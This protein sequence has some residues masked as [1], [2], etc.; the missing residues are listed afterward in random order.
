M[1]LWHIEIQHFIILVMTMNISVIQSTI[2]AIEK[3][4]I[5]INTDYTIKAVNQ[6]YR[7]IYDIDVKLGTSRC[8]EVSHK[9]SQ[10]CDKNGESCP[11]QTCIN[12]GKSSSVVHIHHTENGKQFCDILMKPITDE[13]GITIG[14]L[15]ILEDIN[16]ASVEIHKDKMIG[17]SKPFLHL[18]KQVNRA[19]NSEIAVLLQ[20][21]TGVGKELVAN[22]LHSESKRAKQPFVVIECTG[23][24]EN[25]FES[26]LFGHEKG[27]FTGATQSK[28]GLIDLAHGGTVFFDEI[29]DIPLNMQVKLLRLLETKTY[30]AVGSLKQKT[31]NF[32]FLAATHKDLLKLVEK[33]EFREDL[34]YRIAGFPIHLPALK[35]R[36]EDIP[37]LAQFFLSQTEHATKQFSKQVLNKLSQYKFPGNIRELKNIVEQASLLADNDE[38]QASDLPSYVL[39]KKQLNSNEQKE[40]MT[41]EY[42]EKKHII[43]AMNQYELPADE[44]AQKLGIGIRT[45]YRKLKKHQIDI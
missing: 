29:G 8:Y 13:D 21:Q 31:S 7:D 1:K 43:S 27:A 45:Y 26:E 20:G 5:F 37:L 11:M 34:Y 36:S 15:E 41:L 42:A 38:I 40:N 18:L 10:P 6:A 16:F 28:S 24:S 2:D 23:L 12:T 32:R 39:N 33:G 44:L 35:D 19:A 3:P 9:S 14:Y 25:L 17:S 30:R 4:V 22:A